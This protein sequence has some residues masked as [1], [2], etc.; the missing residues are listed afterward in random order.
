MLHIT[1][2]TANT[3]ATMVTAWKNDIRTFCGTFITIDDVR[4][5]VDLLVGHLPTDLIPCAYV[6]ELDNRHGLD[7]M[8]TLRW[9]LNEKY[10]DFVRAIGPCW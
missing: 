4:G 3:G 1:I 8:L 7:H 9:M 6:I 2:K 10:G 5:L